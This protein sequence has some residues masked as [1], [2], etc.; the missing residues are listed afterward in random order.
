MKGLQIDHTENEL[1]VGQEY[2]LKLQ[3]KGVLD[4]DSEDILENE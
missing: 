3:D 4:E 1:E 2:I